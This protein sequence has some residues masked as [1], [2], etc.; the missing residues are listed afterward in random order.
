MSLSV[1][2]YRARL[3]FEMATLDR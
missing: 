3:S 1:K 2:K